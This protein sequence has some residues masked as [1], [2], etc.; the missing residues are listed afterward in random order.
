MAPALVLTPAQAPE[1][2]QQRPQAALA[3]RNRRHPRLQ[4]AWHAAAA[5]P[6]PPVTLLL[7]TYLVVA[8]KSTVGSQISG[9]ETE[10]RPEPD[11]G[12]FF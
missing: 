12:L 7:Q 1:P 3:N 10:P 11:G 2:A 9:V 4:F 8:A 6:G 5:M